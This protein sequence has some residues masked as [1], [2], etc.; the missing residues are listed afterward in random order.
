M[1]VAIVTESFLPQ[2]NGV[3]GSVLKVCEHLAAEGH[4]AVV[5]A[6]GPGPS[7]YGTTR[8]VRI[9]SAPLPGYA[10]Q[11]VA[12][13]GFRL[14]QAL[15]AFRPDVVHL[16]APTVLGAQAATVAQ[17][18]GV[19]AVAIYQTDLPGYAA[20]YGWRGASQAV[21]SWLRRVHQMAARTLAPSR[22][23]CAELVAHG[24]PDVSRWPRGVDVDRFHPQHR[25]E[26]LRRRLAPRGELVVGYV[27]R[28]AREKEL[29]LL[30]SVHTLP[31]VRLVVAGDGPQRAHLQRTLPRAQFL[32]TVHGRELSG[33]FAS[34]DL[35]VHTGR[36]ETFCQSAQEALASGVPVVAP[37]AGGLLDIVDPGVN[38]TFFAPGNAGELRGTVAL[39]AHD[40]AARRELA[41]RARAS[42]AG[43]DWTSVGRELVD[44]YRAVT[45]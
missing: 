3:T 29:D 36:H 23:A 40:G 18:A 45:V 44:N 32:G 13:P 6:P 4:R 12:Y 11:R 30:R 33:V 20:R 5:I 43:R 24:F 8:V 19:P 38:G 28:L 14:A 25:D 16:A 9:P 17:R 39:L 10:E 37:A 35:F 2:V 26:D 27:G 1:R 34:L 7:R 22:H 21:W 15:R 41:G 31:G 42:I